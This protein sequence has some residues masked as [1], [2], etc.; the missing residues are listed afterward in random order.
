MSPVR[1]SKR[2]AAI[3]KVNHV[4]TTRLIAD[5]S[6][7]ANVLMPKIRCENQIV[8]MAIGGL[9]SQMWLSPQPL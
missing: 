6:R 9:C 7:S 5:G 3:R 4:V 2:S 1:L 8:H